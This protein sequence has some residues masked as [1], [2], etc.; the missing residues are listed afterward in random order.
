MQKKDQ[1]KTM[2][3]ASMEECY[4]VVN[5]YADKVILTMIFIV[6]LIDIHFTLVVYTHWKNHGDR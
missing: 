2:K 4:Q 5:N 1:F 6:I 3:I